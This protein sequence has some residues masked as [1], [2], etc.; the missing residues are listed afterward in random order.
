MLENEM[1]ASTKET[2][3]NLTRTNYLFI[4]SGILI[5]LLLVIVIRLVYKKSVPPIVALPIIGIF[6]L[7]LKNT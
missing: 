5:I 4:L 7:L 1:D 3:D 2:T 6:I